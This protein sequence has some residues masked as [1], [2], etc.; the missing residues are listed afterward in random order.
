MKKLVILFLLMSVTVLYAQEKIE[1][2]AKPMD[3]TSG[4]SL[5]AWTILGTA[6]LNITQAAFSNW[7]AGGENSIGVGALGNLK[8]DYKK[9]KHSWKNN[10]GLAYGFQFLGKGSAARYTKTDDKLEYTTSYGY[11]VSKSWDV[12]FLANFRTQITNGYN[13]PNDSVAISKL[14]APGYLVAGIGMNYVPAEYFQLYMSPAAGRFTFVLDDTLS[15]YGAFGVD[16]DK[17]IKGEFGPYVRAVFNKEVFKNVTLNTSLE[18]FSDYLKDFGNIDVNWNVLIGLKVNKWLSATI[19]TQL[20]YDDDIMIKS[21]PSSEP[22][23]R[24]Q[25]KEVI[26]VGI[27]YTFNH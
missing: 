13:Y 27:S 26:G 15:H 18:L 24:T 3:R 8:A 21:T 23:P 4:D 16:I 19:N 5:K 14:M 17:K 9:N 20:L 1:T 11:A 6:A 12:T 22:G 2:V 7:A 25:F 10:L